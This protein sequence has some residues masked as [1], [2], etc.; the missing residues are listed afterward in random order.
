MIRNK[1]VIIIN[2]LKMSIIFIAHLD[3]FG[4]CECTKCNKGES[5]SLKNIDRPVSSLESSDNSDN[6]DNKIVKD[7]INKNIEDKNTKDDNDKKVLKDDNDNNDNKIVKD[8]INKNDEDKN[9]KDGSDKKDDHKDDDNNKIDKDD[10]ENNEIDFETYK[11]FIEIFKINLKDV[12]VPDDIIDTCEDITIDLDAKIYLCFKFIVLNIRRQGDENIKNCV[13]YY[14]RKILCKKNKNGEEEFKKYQKYI[15]KEDEEGNYVLKEKGDKNYLAEGGFG[16]VYKVEEQGKTYAL[17]CIDLSC[18]DVGNF[19][20]IINE[21][22]ITETFS[23]ESNFVKM[24]K[25]FVDG[26][27]LYLLLDCY[28]YDMFKVINFFARK[29]KNICKETREKFYYQLI[30]AL[31]KI[32]D[33][34]ITH[35]DLKIENIFLDSSDNVYIGDFGISGYYEEGK[36]YSIKLNADSMPNI[37]INK[38]KE[39]EDSG[40]D[41]YYVKINL[42]KNDIYALGIIMYCLLFT[43]LNP[44]INHNITGKYDDFFEE[45]K[46]FFEDRSNIED[47]DF[48][49]LLDIMLSEDL[50]KGVSMDEVINSEYYKY[51]DKKY[52]KK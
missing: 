8:D 35:N 44:L 3:I 18:Y 34:G 42:K 13:D 31:K 47:K 37:Y 25:Y 20:Q 39:I 21:I 27:F 7:D 19:L 22:E 33:K 43:G 48:S 38:M 12:G 50:D 5:Q 6:N 9:N 4:R 1:S 29:K 23:N 2:K 14:L 52:C 36:E 24:H 15:F 41:N 40:S 32:H 10:D 51:L 17:K 45:K 16:R 30:N 49:N 26:N 46:K 11:K 28:L